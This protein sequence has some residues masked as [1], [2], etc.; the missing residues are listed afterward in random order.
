[1]VGVAGHA[2]HRAREVSAGP[3]AEPRPP[4]LPP[5]A[6]SSSVSVRTAQ[7]RHISTSE[8]ASALEDA[9]AAV[10]LLDARTKDEV[11]CGTRGYAGAT[12]LLP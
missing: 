2:S 3:H 6:S 4:R 7:A 9:D 11:R 12:A 10:L 8:L 5:A 1:V